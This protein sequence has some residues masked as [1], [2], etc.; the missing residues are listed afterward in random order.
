MQSKQQKDT[1]CGFEESAAD[2]DARM[3]IE[4]FATAAVQRNARMQSALAERGLD[5]AANSPL[6]REMGNA[7]FMQ[8]QTRCENIK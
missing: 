1:E 8:T 2:I 6:H 5:W 7:E 4:E 3:K